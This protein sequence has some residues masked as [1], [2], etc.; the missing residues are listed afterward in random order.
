MTEYRIKK[1]T[2]GD[3]IKYYPQDKIGWFWFDMDRYGFDTYEKAQK[4]LRNYLKEPVV[5]YLEY[6]VDD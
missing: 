3:I 6:I 5:E 2:Q 4:A 1:V